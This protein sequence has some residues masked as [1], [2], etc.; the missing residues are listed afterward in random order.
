MERLLS[1]PQTTDEWVA[2]TADFVGVTIT[3]LW[4]SGAIHFASIMLHIGIGCVTFLSVSFS[5]YL[6]VKNYLK[7]RK[8]GQD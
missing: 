3:I 5:L 2:A 1:M 4:L 8:H 6:K 7:S